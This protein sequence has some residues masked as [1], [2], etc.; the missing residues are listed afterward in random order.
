VFP[1]NFPLLSPGANAEAE[2]H[3]SR[4][5]VTSNPNFRVSES[6]MEDAVTQIG[7]ELL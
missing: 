4:L 2:Q 5:S 6:Q 3:S 1:L 7:E